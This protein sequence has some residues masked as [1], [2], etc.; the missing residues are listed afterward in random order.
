MRRRSFD[1]ATLADIARILDR[2]PPVLLDL[3]G[4]TRAAVA[5]ILR[6]GTHG[7]EVLF[8]ERAPRAGDPWAGDLGFPG[9]KEE[10]ADSDPRQ[11]AERETREEVGLDLRDGRYLGRLSD[12]A[13][14]HLPVQVS[15]FVYGVDDPPPF[16]MNEEVRD[17]F[18]VALA[19]L[20]A[21]ARHVAAP[22]R[23]G[24][25]MLA[26]PAIRLPQPGKPVLWG[27]TYRL[28]MQFL[29]L[30]GLEKPMSGQI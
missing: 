4:H 28:V 1:P 14:A 8:I 7:L 27:I 21:P 23:F 9:G 13:G 25:E 19:D 16:A 6:G 3:P 29:Q 11:S 18:W 10:E 2:H 26:R 5:L 30:L 20:C 22:V 24:G 17:V 15:C 12:I